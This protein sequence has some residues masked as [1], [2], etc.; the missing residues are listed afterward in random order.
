M[1]RLLFSE[2]GGEDAPLDAGDTVEALLPFITSVTSRHSG[3]SWDYSGGKEV[4]E[5]PW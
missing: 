1:T 2:T 4:V 3:K 5:Y